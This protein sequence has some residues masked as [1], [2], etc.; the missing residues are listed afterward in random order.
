MSTSTSDVA[1][2]WVWL[3]GQTEPVPSG[4]LRR[5]GTRYVF[6]YGRRYLERPDAI[7][8]YTPTLPLRPGWIEPPD[9]WVVAPNLRDAAPDAWGRR[10]ILDRIAGDR[11]R[12]ADVDQ[13]D[14]LTYMLESGSNRIGG[15]DFQPTPTAYVARD[16]VAQ[17]DELYDAATAL[18]EGRPLSDALRRA[19]GSG[20]AIGGARPKAY[21]R[22]GGRELI[23]KFA[24]ST[25]VLPMV[26]AEAAA[27]VMAA[28]AGI[29]VPAARVVRSRGRYALVMDRFDRPETGGRRIVISA[30]TMVGAGETLVPD[31]SYPDI[32][33][34]LRSHGADGSAAEQLFRRIAFS[35]AIT[36]TDDHLRNHAAFWDG[37]T[38]ALTPAYDLSPSSRSGD[39]ASLTLAYD[40]DGGRRADLAGLARAAHVYGLS[41]PRAREVIDEVVE[42]VHD[43]WPRAADHAELTRAQQD[44]LWGTQFLHRSIFYDYGKHLVDHPDGPTVRIGITSSHGS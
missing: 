9:D 8:L 18:E 38:L 30:M 4:V 19:L 23:A 21:L 28:A 17:L 1:Y 33:D 20:T 6:Q 15:I 44:R 2:V 42:A 13:L 11:G 35:I 37:R 29:D 31:G 12:D 5:R 27:I 26:Q 36:N 25:D 22:D 41:T 16:D 7:S 40:R 3:P 34:A 10:V 14:E 39:S 32:L 43:S 24:S